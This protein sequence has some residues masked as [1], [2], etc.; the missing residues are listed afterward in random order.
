MIGLECSKLLAS[1]YR[2][3]LLLAGRSLERIKPVARELQETFGVKV[4][5]DKGAVDSLQAIICNAGAR[6]S[7][8]G[9]LQ[10]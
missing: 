10:R 2:A 7:G 6:L 9:H 4:R 8:P 1:H 3:N 5:L